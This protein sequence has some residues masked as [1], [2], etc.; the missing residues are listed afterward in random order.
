MRKNA[1][2]ILMILIIGV[3][4]GCSTE[5][6]PSVERLEISQ[7]RSICNLATL[8]CYYHNVAKID[9]KAGTGIAHIGEVDRKLWIEY[10]GYVTIGID[11]SKVTMEVE[12][13]KVT[14]F[15]PDATV[16]SVGYDAESSDSLFASDDS[17]FNKNSITA[18]EQREAISLAQASMEDAANKNATLLMAAQNRAQ[19]LIENYIVQ[20]GQLSNIEYEIEWKHEKNEG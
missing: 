9:K 4:A 15:I 2:I 18:D 11:M 16:L 14:V 17:W 5:E 10:T 3:F 1:I 7:I 8:K 12:N 6:E 20:M 19:E 13:E